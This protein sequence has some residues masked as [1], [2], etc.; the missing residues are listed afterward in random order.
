M[1]SRPAQSFSTKSSPHATSP[2]NSTSTP[3]ATTP[4]TSPNISR[5]RSNSTPV[6]SPDLR[7]ANLQIAL[8]LRSHF[9]LFFSAP[10]SSLK[11]TRAHT[12]LFL[13][14]ITLNGGNVPHDRVLPSTSN[15]AFTNSAAYSRV[16]TKSAITAT[17]P[18]FN[19]R[20]I[21]R[22]AS[23]LPWRD[24][25][26][27]ITRLDTTT[28]NVPSANR[29]DLASPSSTSTFSF[30]LSSTAFR[31]VRSSTF[32]ERSTK[33]HTSMPV[34][35]PVVNLFA[36]PI[37]SNPAPVPTS[38]TRSSPRQFTIASILSRWR[39]FM[40]FEYTSISTPPVAQP[41][42]VLRHIGVIITVTPPT[43]TVGK[44]QII[45]AHAAAAT[46]KFRITPGASIP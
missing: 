11:A 2:T 5:P 3:G 33:L 31:S 30:T 24:G 40:N 10:C 1:A 21:S 18:G 32:P 12:H 9:W 17:P 15:P 4:P 36:A 45:A 38:S 37:N 42:A 43:F 29:I 22:H 34:A 20:A 6:S 41:I 19:T 7:N 14:R 28:S 25:M 23:S 44:I 13:A 26:L 35:F 8:L 46:N 16:F 39:N 27:W